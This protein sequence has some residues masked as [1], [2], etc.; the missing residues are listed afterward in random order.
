MSADFITT[1][2]A[3]LTAANLPALLDKCEEASRQIDAIR[4][5][6]REVLADGGHIPGWQLMN[7]RRCDVLDPAA[8]FL[9][10]WTD[11]GREIALQGVRLS[12]PAV[13]AAMRQETHISTDKARETINRTLD[14]LL[15][16]YDSPRLVRER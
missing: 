15:A 12:M 1:D 5:R 2:P 3:G 10:I 4:A 11:H 8:A 16:F 9:R 6:A 7:V 14:G 13:A